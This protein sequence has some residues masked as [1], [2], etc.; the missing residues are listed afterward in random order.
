MA[1][2]LALSLLLL[3]ALAAPAHAGYFAAEPI[4]GPAGEVLAFSD[5]DLA[6]DG[7]GGLVYLRSDGGAPHVFLSRFFAGEWH[8]P[9]RVDVG[10]DTAATGAAIA[11]GDGNRL[12]I[13]FTTGARVFGSVASGG[14]VVPLGAP[15]LLYADPDPLKDVLTPSVDLGINGAA[16]VAF[17]AP[18]AGGTDVRAARLEGASW[19]AVPQP[20]DIDLNAEAGKGAG[21]P[22]VGVSAEGNAVVTWGESNRVFARRLTGLALSV[23]PQEVSVREFAGGGGGDADSP[24]ID[25]EDDGSYAWVTWRQD[26]GGTSRALARR[27]VG[28]LFEPT[29]TVDNGGA[30][31]LPS[32]DM[33]GRGVGF[34]AAGLY[35]NGVAG[36]L[37]EFDAFKPAFRLDGSGGAGV[38]APT[39]GFGENENALIAWRREGG[40]IGAS[41][42]VARY[43]ERGKALEGETTISNPALAGVP[44]GHVGAA[45]DR[46]GNVAIAFLQGTEAARTIAVASYD[47]RPG[48][49]VGLNTTRYQRRSRPTFK[50]RVG[51]ERWGP[52]TYKVFIDGQ[53]I[54]TSQ[55]AAYTPS[56]P[57]DDG[58]HRW[59]VI[60]YDRRGQPAPSRARW[61]RIDATAPAVEIAVRGTRKRNRTLTIDVDATDE[62]SRLKS[63]TVQYGDGGRTSLQDTKYRYRRPGAFTI[64]V[65]AVDNAGNVANA[66]SRIRIK[67]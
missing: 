3:A 44:A 62:S 57:L 45:A 10:V 23:A 35:S 54:G 59:Q 61:L 14:P 39:I 40:S 17:T 52:Q 48:L 6:R 53:E 27:L 36:A 19:A 20:L 50:W 34:A 56:V 2:L 38:P 31:G 21:R 4:D 16:Y 65:R 58:A 51:A 28:S 25:I 1:R 55:A 49:P 46:S 30:S 7:T 15:T 29:V 63:V 43:R 66:E 67:K 64:R 32:I 60:A 24:D 26:I 12:A 47:R 42:V 18:G 37:L 33:N 8:A 9:E 13:A 22:R 5:I 41:T 11:V